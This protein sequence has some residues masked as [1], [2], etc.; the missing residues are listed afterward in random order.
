MDLSLAA[1]EAYQNSYHAR[2]QLQQTRYYSKSCTLVGSSARESLFQST[3]FLSG[4][5]V[6]ASFAEP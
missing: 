5:D 2:W 4:V 3:G 1:L 6:D